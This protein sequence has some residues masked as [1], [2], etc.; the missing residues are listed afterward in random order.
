MYRV[1]GSYMMK[2]HVIGRSVFS[3]PLL[4]TRGAL[5][6]SLS[7]ASASYGRQRDHR[8]SSEL[9]LYS[10]TLCITPLGMGPCYLPSFARRKTLDS[11]FIDVLGHIVLY[12]SSVQGAW[13]G[14]LPSTPITRREEGILFSFYFPRHSASP[15]IPW[16]P[17]PLSP[18]QLTCPPL[19]FKNKRKR[20]ILLKAVLLV[21][22]W[23]FYKLE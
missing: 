19:A 18:H 20:R 15:Q 16:L 8:K 3:Y 5:A 11:C 14:M 2:F 1:L 9:C 21:Q 7:V 10:P 12:F 13:E 17:S 4:H 23:A 6:L 22:S